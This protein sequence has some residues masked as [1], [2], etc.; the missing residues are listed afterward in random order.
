MTGERLKPGP[1]GHGILSNNGRAVR[2]RAQ[3]DREN[4]QWRGENSR[5]LPGALPAD[6]RKGEIIG[7][8]KDSTADVSPPAPAPAPPAPAAPAPD[9][10]VIEYFC[11]DCKTELVKWQKTCTGC[12]LD[13][14]WS[15]LQT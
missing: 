5:Q 12:E 10:D 3:R 13:I 2:W 15:T 7:V 14:D 8:F 6:Y 11:M 4:A 9:V 1:Q